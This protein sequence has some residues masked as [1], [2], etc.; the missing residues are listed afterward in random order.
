MIILE[1]TERPDGNFDF[2]AMNSP[3]YGRY[4]IVMA[5]SSPD[6]TAATKD[7]KKAGCWIAAAGSSV[8][9]D[10]GEAYKLA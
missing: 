1:A 3:F 5:A 2:L 8:M 6:Y 4:A 7:E 10:G 9:S